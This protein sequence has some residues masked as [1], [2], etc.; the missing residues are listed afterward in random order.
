MQTTDTERL[1]DT[2]GR[3]VEALAVAV[4]KNCEVVL[5]DLSNPERSIVAIANGHVTGRKVGDTLDALGLQLLRQPPVDD[6]LNYQSKTKD[7]R[8]LRSSSIFLRDDSGKIFGAVCVNMDVTVPI[9]FEEWLKDIIDKGTTDLDEKF[10]DSV[11]EVLDRLIQNAVRTTGK[12]LPSELTREEKISVISQLDAKGAFLIRYSVDHV[13][14]FL[15]ISKFT[16]YSYLEEI[17]SKRT[18]AESTGTAL[19]E[20]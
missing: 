3:L 1:L 18:A 8:V 7:G 5:H 12:G 9:K 15:E 17:K 19:A 13:A 20:K 11:D 6:L 14:K 16:I 2:L 10:E 4:G